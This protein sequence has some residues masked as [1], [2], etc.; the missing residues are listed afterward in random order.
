MRKKLEKLKNEKNDM[1]EQKL[2]LPKPKVMDKKIR[3]VTEQIEVAEKQYFQVTTIIVN[4][5]HFSI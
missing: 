1:Q 2:H 5:F 3:K 4:A